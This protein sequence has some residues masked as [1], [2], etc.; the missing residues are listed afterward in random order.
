MSGW[1]RP[2][3]ILSR[4]DM[5]SSCFYKGP[6]QY[7]NPNGENLLIKILGETITTKDTGKRIVLPWL[8]RQRKYVRK[9]NDWA[10]WFHTNV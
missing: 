6:I 7:S 9:L 4:E 3:N 5:V 10:S 2:R 8:R 1:E